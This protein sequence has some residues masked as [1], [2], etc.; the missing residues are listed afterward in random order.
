MWALKKHRVGNVRTE[1]A[2]HDISAQVQIEEAG[3]ANHDKVTCFPNSV[4]FPELKGYT[5][6]SANYTT[7]FTNP[8]GFYFSP[9]AIL[10]NSESMCIQP[11]TK[12]LL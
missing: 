1:K 10:A 5:V 2:Q 4:A 6:A 7:K 9:T 11:I 12:Y 3:E 8:F